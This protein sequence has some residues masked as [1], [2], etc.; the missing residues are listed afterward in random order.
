MWHYGYN[1]FETG[2]DKGNLV[3]VWQNQIM[4]VTTWEIALSRK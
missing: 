1:Q 2:E 3:M 4:V